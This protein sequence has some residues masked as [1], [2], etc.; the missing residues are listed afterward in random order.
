MHEVRMTNQ[1]HLMLNT[2][3]LMLGVNASIGAIR[4][5]SNELEARDE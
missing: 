1:L 4:K 5:L 3:E 2:E